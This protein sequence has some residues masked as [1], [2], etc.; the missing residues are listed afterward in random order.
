MR[1]IDANELKQQ[2][3]DKLVIRVGLSPKKAREFANTAFDA[4]FKIIDNAPTIEAVPLEDYR[5]ME[6]TVHKLTQALA[7]AE[8]FKKVVRC[9][10][11]KHWDNHD[12]GERCLNSI[13]LSWAKPENSCNY[14]ER[15]DEVEE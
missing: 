3:V 11:C 9:K 5:S 8:P 1:L 15:K 14:G 7:E 6:Q 10:D 13:Y 2:F 12:G 4:I